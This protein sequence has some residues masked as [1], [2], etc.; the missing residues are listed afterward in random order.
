MIV[1]YARAFWKALLLTLHGQQIASTPL[2]EPQIHAWMREAVRL[3]D[4]VRAA[5]ERAGV[6][7]EERKAWILHIDKRD[8]ALDT[9][10]QTIRHHLTTEYP[11]LL[12][13]YTKYSVMTIQASNLNDQYLAT[14]FAEAEVLP[15]T[16]REALA[17]LRDHLAAIPPAQAQT[18]AQP[19]ET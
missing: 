1:R 15:A 11:Y 2:N 18:E 7:L 6:T 10:L 5:Q 19:T 9:A 3:A 8:L 13:H 17:T 16:V 4:A 14:R 12:K